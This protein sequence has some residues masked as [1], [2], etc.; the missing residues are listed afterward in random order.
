VLALTVR[1]TPFLYAGEELGLE[2]GVVP[3]D[4]VVD[5]DGRDGCRSPIP[6]TIDGDE[7]VGHGW[8]VRPWLPFPANASTH[9]ASAQIGVPGSMHSLYRAL[10]ALRHRDE[11]LRRGSIEF[12]PLDGDVI[13][14]ERTLGDDGVT[15]LV[16]LSDDPAPWPADLV[17]ADLLVS[18]DAARRAIGDQLAPSEAVILRRITAGTS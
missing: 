4:R 13:R 6:W 3:P 1:G 16:N 9:A 5:P 17:Q 11:V 15:V 7:E 14:F 8:P 18:S 10:L 12:A 2:D